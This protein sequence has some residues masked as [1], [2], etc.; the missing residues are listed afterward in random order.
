M[1]AARAWCSRS[2][3][4]P[5]AASQSF[6]NKPPELCVSGGSFRI[7]EIGYIRQPRTILDLAMT[8]PALGGIWAAMRHQPDEAQ[9][10]RFAHPRLYR[11]PRQ[12]TLHRL[13]RDH[14]L[15]VCHA[16]HMFDSLCAGAGRRSATSRS[17]EGPYVSAGFKSPSHTWS[18]F[19]SPG[20]AIIH[21]QRAMRAG[22]LSARQPLSA[23]LRHMTRKYLIFHQCADHTAPRASSA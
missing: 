14:R 9:P 22:Y 2:C 21:R 17:V 8:S 5:S 20:A 11:A 19:S 16:G 4:A 12:H 7:V 3:P 15:R 23:T 10:Q 18:R 1:Q 13:Q 6:Q